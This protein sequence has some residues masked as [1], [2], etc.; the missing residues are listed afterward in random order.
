MSEGA[1]A[2][3]LALGAAR[4]ERERALREL[5]TAEAHADF[6]REPDGSLPVIDPAVP[7]NQQAF[8]E[9]S[10][11]QPALDAATTH[12]ESAEAA[13]TAAAQAYTTLAAQEPLFPEANQAPILLLPVRLEAVYG[14]SADG[15][16]ELRVRVFPDDVHVDSHERGLTEGEQ[17][18]GRAH[19]EAVHA[20][21]TDQERAAAWDTL[22]SRAAR[23]A[24]W[25]REA[26][27]PTN[28]PPAAP[29]FPEV[30]TVDEAWTRAAHTR[31]LP[32]HFE[33]SAYR[34]GVLQWRT[35]GAAIP[36]TLPLGVAPTSAG[37][38][39]DDD[40][41]P[42][43]PDSRWLADFMKA[44]A[45][46]MALAV[47]IGSPDDRFDLL[48]AV[49]IGSQDAAT[50]GTRL[51]EQLVAHSHTGGLS[52]VP[53]RTPTNNT[54]GSRSAWRSRQA[55]LSPS[56]RDARLAGFD[57]TSEQ[58]AA[59]LGRALGI[60][61][62]RTLAP[63]TDP[64]DEHAELAAAL[65]RLRARSLMW[66]RALGPVDKA[67]LDE[68]PVDEPWLHAAADHFAAYVRGRGP[69]PLLRIG[70]QPYGVLPVSSLDVW[71]G[72]A[73]DDLMARHV[74]SF[75]AAFA[76]HHDRAARI[77]EGPDQD[78]VLIDLLSFQATPRRLAKWFHQ[79]SGTEGRP[80][81]STA[82]AIPASM[83]LAWQTFD[84]RRTDEGQPIEPD[85]FEPL[86]D[87]L[88]DELRAFLQRR[89]LAQLLVLF[90]ETIAT[91]RQTHLAP[92]EAD[93][94]AVYVPLA[95]VLE[96]LCSAPTRSFFYSQ[97]SWSSN[98]M[99]N[100]LRGGP[101]L[102]GEVDRAVQQAL[103]YRKHF[104]PFV[105]LED[106]AV[107]DLATVEALYRETTDPVSQRVDAWVTS[108]ATRRLHELRES[109]A[110]GIRTG[111]YG[112]LTEVEP[113][114]PVPSREGFL[115]T[116]SLHHAAT[117][118][119]LRSGWQAH[120][121]RGAFAVDIQSARARRAQAVIEGVRAGQELTA[122]L[123]YQFERAL[124]DAHLDRFVRG[125]RAA[126][127]HAPLVEPD[128]VDQTAAR[129][130]IGAR[131]VV[132]GQALRRDRAT[133]DADGALLAA[134]GSDLGADAPA[135]RRM[136]AELDETFD[137]VGDLVLAESVHQLVGG[138][139]MR[140]G[141][142]ADVAGRGQD[143]PT[144]YDVLRT[145]R[146][147][148]PLTHHVAIGLT[149][150]PTPGWADNRPLARLEPRLEGWLRRRLGPAD[151]WPVG[152]DLGASWC[153]FDALLATPT[154]ITAAVVAAGG[155]PDDA[156][157]ERL[158]VVSERLRAVLA[159]CTPLTARHL[160]P[161]A[162]RVGGSLDLHD[163]DA[164]LRPWWA[165]VGESATKYADAADAA[166]RATVLADLTG[167]GVLPPA[168]AETG[169]FPALQAATAELPP[170]PA[171]DAE[172]GAAD[173]WLER[174]LRTVDRLLH[175]AV[176][177]T[178]A[179]TSTPPT[180]PA[181]DPTQDE[182]TDWLRD[183][184]LVR[185][186]VE[187]LDVAL[188][189]SEVLGGA[190]PARLRV[191]QQVLDA[192][193]AAP[194]S[195]TGAPVE[196]TASQGSVVLVTDG[197]AAVRAGLV[198]DGWSETVPHAAD[199]PDEV[200][201]IAFDFDRPGARPPQAMLVAVPPDLARGWC[202]EDVH[203]CVE[204]TLA[205]SKVRMLDLADLPELAAL[206]LVDEVG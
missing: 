89:P 110:D 179:L 135:L 90:D 58:E 78:A 107:Q 3:R 117:A 38:G 94:N 153:A 86:P 123:G 64:A 127:P 181:P 33:F 35:A 183:Q 180:A 96:Q 155:V 201:G 15:D 17:R 144:D 184:V 113:T 102:P 142:A 30:D 79:V 168:G 55:P 205:L 50:G 146:T 57:Q 109:G 206:P 126:Y 156:V 132:D 12:V 23:R 75:Q 114:T 133:L 151:A 67:M 19:W 191:H 82:G 154:S 162:D 101:A 26:L 188:V 40:E 115:Q 161:A 56:E 68:T 48:T 61:G 14:T 81:P 194:W 202:L 136:I 51:Q 152:T 124:H 60:D 111:G 204:E 80:P 22:V 28:Q 203:G 165:K 34:D 74:G 85:W 150:E 163:L 134:A 119:V 198:V 10:G 112:W 148:I 100:V 84:V 175:P 171:A 63:A 31:L 37:D 32:H 189:A 173:A 122:L 196:S 9:V 104:A 187:T 16:P 137:A 169:A 69:H 43:D 160:D 141:I 87:P 143:L 121:D 105:D 120:Q 106:E 46:G 195:A 24:T 45:V 186:Q 41:I 129:V 11:L 18:A 128:A 62:A 174:L 29:T 200:T 1:A 97:A 176:R 83:A 145:P 108:L 116:P 76:E 2:A 131:N 159:G 88:P 157:V 47:P 130:A 158:A 21:T 167:L 59:R 39:A 149:D 118:A 8:E 140:A 7:G 185:P 190:A 178:A 70:R 166:A 44:R 147:G 52:V 99:S 73:P 53:P 66:S 138:S 65:H 25:V 6:W 36:D 197:D 98:A 177:V 27:T 54:A 182:V 71:I 77:L 42:L 172:P 4:V 20:A 164:R 95:T 193:A 103:R 170:L 92:V 192:A 93:F 72:A 91:M 13:H 139:P 199:S 5:R 49:G 125:F